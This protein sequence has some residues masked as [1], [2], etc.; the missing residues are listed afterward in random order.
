[1]VS[2]TFP[3]SDL[4]L[5]KLTDSVDLQDRFFQLAGQMDELVQMSEVEKG[6]AE[7]SAMSVQ[8][9]FDRALQR[10]QDALQAMAHASQGGRLVEGELSAPATE[11]EGL[12]ASFD[13]PRRDHAS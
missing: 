8:L 11:G 2:L 12:T 5:C 13:G 10:V 3:T 6:R 7:E 9:E 4:V 1:M